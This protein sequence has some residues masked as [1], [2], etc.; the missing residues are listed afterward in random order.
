MSARLQLPDT[1]Q[2]YR[3]KGD[4]T[5]GRDSSNDICLQ[6]SAT[7][8]HHAMIRRMG[9]NDYYLVDTGSTNGSRLN[10]HRCATPTLLQHRDIITIGD[11]RLQFLNEDD[12]PQ[13]TLTENITERTVI[14]NNTEVE[15]I[16]I[17][18]ADI[19]QYTSLS[20]QMPIADLTRL[21]NRWFDEATTCIREH[22]GTIDKFI[23]DC[24]YARWPCNDSSASSIIQAMQAAIRLQQ[25][26]S[27]ISKDTAGLQT[28]LQIGIGINTGTAAVNIGRDNTAI[29]DS[30]NLAFRLESQSK[31]IG[32]DIIL[33]S[34]SYQRLPGESWKGREHSITIKGKSEPVSVIGLDFDEAD[35]L[36][37]KFS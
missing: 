18:V 34:D 5:I 17:L 12:E 11:T 14:V 27:R 16:T 2:E 35:K 10:G 3:C 20:E 4:L 24:V 9:K 6:D 31:T 19:R 15:D 30:V 36:I 8:R 29:G 37:S 22:H 21:M 25:L 23:G 28:P 33:G 26:S 13:S 32:K 7:S 1:G